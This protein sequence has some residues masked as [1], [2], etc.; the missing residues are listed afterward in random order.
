MKKTR[1]KERGSEVARVL[2]LPSVRDGL[3]ELVVRAGASAI[4]TMLAEDVVRIC[5]ERYAR[6]NEDAPRRWGH[7]E[8]AA[9]LGGR[10]VRIERPR[11]RKGGREVALP[12]YGQLQQEDPLE[13]RALE[14]MLLGVSTRGYKRSL[15]EL[16]SLDTFGASKSA[17]SR[18]FVA[19]TEAQL[20]TMMSARLDRTNWAAVML[21]ALNFSEHVIVVALGI[22]VSGKKHL[23]GLRE[24]STENATLCTE[25]LTS[26]VER[27]LPQEKHL[28]FV[29]DGGK[30]LRKAI[31]DVFGGFGLVQRCQVHKARNVLDHLPEEK[32]GQVRA[33]LSQAYA[34]NSYATA[35]R[36]LKNLARTLAAEHPGAAES[37]REGLEETLTV[38]KLNLTG[39]LERSLATTNPIENMNGTVRRISNRV[40]RCRGGSM[41]LRWVA[42]AMLEAKR[43]FRRLRG[44]KDMPMLITQL[45]ALDSQKK[46]AN[47]RKTG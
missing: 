46:N 15:E 25:L 41:A 38:K 30:G 12:T 33:V 44:H 34:A 31:R 5:G 26:L 28:L 17:V 8:G 13:E 27:G 21:D 19:A 45:H 2:P 9:V 20:E 4:T 22:D 47:V 37:V 39:R 10:R 40:K 18:R 16:S 36:Q 7:Q 43:G 14:Q 6:R 32:R 42:G 11:V 29:I 35:E 23:L 1:R 3:L 24:G